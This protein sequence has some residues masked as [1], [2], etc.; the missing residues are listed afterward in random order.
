LRA[1]FMDAYD[2]RDDWNRFLDTYDRLLSQIR[3]SCSTHT[4]NIDDIFENREGPIER[5]LEYVS[6]GYLKEAKM[7]VDRRLWHAQA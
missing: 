2:S 1:P 4:I 7:Q 3:L 5:M 6:R